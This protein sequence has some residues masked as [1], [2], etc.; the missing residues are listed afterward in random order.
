MLPSSKP[1]WW[2][3]GLTRQQKR[4]R[5]IDASDTAQEALWTLEGPITSARTVRGGSLRAQQQSYEGLQTL[6]SS[7]YRIPWYHSM[8]Y[9][10]YVDGFG[11]QYRVIADPASSSSGGGATAGT[12]ASPNDPPPAVLAANIQRGTGQLVWMH[13]RNRWHRAVHNLSPHARVQL[14]SAPMTDERLRGDRCGEW[15]CSQQVERDAECRVESF[16]PAPCGTHGI[17][18]CEFQ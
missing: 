13:V 14:R 16:E 8:E 10:H 12:D 9:W 7:G 3:S 1:G 17:L 2:G 15:G 18:L 4:E 5:A 6:A 11:N